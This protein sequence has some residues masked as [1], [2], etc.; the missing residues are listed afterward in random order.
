MQQRK[1]EEFKK[2]SVW[3]K[4]SCLPSKTSAGG[5][6]SLRSSGEF[7]RCFPYEYGSVMVQVRSNCGKFIV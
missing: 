5:L 6:V 2:A 7:R 3:A 1:G 4:K